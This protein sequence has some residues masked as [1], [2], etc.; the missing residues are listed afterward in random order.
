MKLNLN[1]LEGFYLKVMAIK[2][3][4]RILIYCVVLFHHKFDL[5]IVLVRSHIQEHIP[6]RLLYEMGLLKVLSDK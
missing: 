5:L 4:L 6:I 3:C 2:R 1:S